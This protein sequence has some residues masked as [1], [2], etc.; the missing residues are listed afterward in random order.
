MS[1]GQTVADA[2]VH[3]EPKVAGQ[4]AQTTRVVDLAG[5]GRY[6][7]PVEKYPAASPGEPETDRRVEETAC[8]TR[9]LMK[10]P[11]LGAQIRS[12]DRARP[13]AAAAPSRAT[14]WHLD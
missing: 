13:T 2:A 4:G 9:A 7:V 14:R 10:R 1:A 3:V 12:R 8:R 5:C 11:A 6:G